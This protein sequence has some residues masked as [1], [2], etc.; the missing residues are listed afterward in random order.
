MSLTKS[1]IACC[2]CSAAQWRKLA[3]SCETADMP[4]GEMPLWHMLGLVI[5]E[6]E[7]CIL[8][9]FGHVGREIDVD[10]G[11]LII[12]GV[13][14]VVYSR[15]CVLVLMAKTECSGEIQKLG[16]GSCYHHIT[17]PTFVHMGQTNYSTYSQQSYCQ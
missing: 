13:E 15:Y 6:P 5:S 7:V 8:D 11:A 16:Y 10:W 14:G 4:N 9:V 2:A 17:M 3:V 1:Y 12:G